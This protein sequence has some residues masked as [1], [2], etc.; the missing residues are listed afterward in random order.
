MK[1]EIAR[2]LADLE[3]ALVAA[4]LSEEEAE[5]L[6]DSLELTIKEQLG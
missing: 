1:R 4:G 5:E 3:E 6:I 2:I